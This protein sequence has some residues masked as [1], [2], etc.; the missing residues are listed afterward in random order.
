MKA[1]DSQDSLQVLFRQTVPV[2]FVDHLTRRQRWVYEEANRQ[3]YDNPLWTEAEARYILGHTERVLFENEMRK[4]AV[5]FGIDWE[6]AN[7][8]GDNCTYVKV[9][10]GK[11][12]MTGHRVPCP[13]YFV[14]PAESRK[15]EAAVNR[16][17]DGYVLDGAL[18]IPLPLLKQAKQIAAYILHGTTVD[19]NGEKKLFLQLAIPDSELDGYRWECSFVDLRQAYSMGLRHKRGVFRGPRSSGPKTAEGSKKKKRTNEIRN[20]WICWFKTDRGEGGKGVDRRFTRR[21]TG[22]Q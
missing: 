3:C 14:R 9:V 7:H 15:Q 17:M 10:S 19:E 13:G 12:K 2:E 1:D 8:V 5:S 4:G 21:N 18:S 11:F 16:F 20:S 22:N 6:N